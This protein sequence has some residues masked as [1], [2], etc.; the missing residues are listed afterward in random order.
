MLPAKRS[1]YAPFN[2][3]ARLPVVKSSAGAQNG[4]AVD[5]TRIRV[6]DGLRS[7]E[8]PSAFRNGGKVRDC[9]RKSVTANNICPK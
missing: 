8:H 7:L 9:A 3:A 5:F 1:G 2:R 6:S 4:Q